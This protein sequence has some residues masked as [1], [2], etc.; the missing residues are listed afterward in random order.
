MTVFDW[1]KG[2]IYSTKIYLINNLKQIF[3]VIKKNRIHQTPLNWVKSPIYG[4]IKIN[5]YNNIF[6]CAIFFFFRKNTEIKSGMCKTDDLYTPIFVYIN[7][8]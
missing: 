4:D 6:N 5:G 7:D 2:N 1:V 3:Y 8:I